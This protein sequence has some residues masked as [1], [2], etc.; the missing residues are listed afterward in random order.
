MI[1]VLNEGHQCL[2]PNMG[3]LSTHNELL[4]DAS[5]WIYIHVY[6][7]ELFATLFTNDKIKVCDYV[8]CIYFVLHVYLY[9]YC[10]DQHAWIHHGRP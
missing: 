2:L 6:M 4:T 7:Y 5:L 8:S 9:M 1:A 3:I 10:R